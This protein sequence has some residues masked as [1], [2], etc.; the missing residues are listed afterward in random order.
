MR[1]EIERGNI[2]SVRTTSPCKRW[3]GIALLIAMVNWATGCSVPA[4]T[5]SHGVD[6]SDEELLLTLASLAR[7]GAEA[8]CNPQMLEKEL[9]IKM[10]PTVVKIYPASDG[11]QI[12]VQETKNIYSEQRGDVFETATYSRVRSPGRRSDC[13]LEIIFRESRLCAAAAAHTQALLGTQTIISDPPMHSIGYGYG[14]NYRYETATGVESRIRLGH[15]NQQCANGFSLTSNGE[16][17]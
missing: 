16:W 3:I 11:K 12:E 10:G 15:S 14:Y 2:R 4:S 6:A 17:R 1:V 5:Q 7:R 8:V 9:N 13:R